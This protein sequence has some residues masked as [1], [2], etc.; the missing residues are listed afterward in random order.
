MM[1]FPADN[2]GKWDDGVVIDVLCDDGSL[3]IAKKVFC[4]ELVDKTNTLH[5]FI[6][7]PLANDLK[8]LVKPFNFQQSGISSVAVDGVHGQIA[9]HCTLHMSARVKGLQGLVDRRFVVELSVVK[10]WPE[11]SCQI[12]LG[13]RFREEQQ[14]T[15]SPIWYDTVVDYDLSNPPKSFIVCSND[16]VVNQGTVVAKSPVADAVVV[17]Q[18]TVVAKPP[19]AAAVVNSPPNSGAIVV[20]DNVAADTS[21]TVANLVGCVDGEETRLP[22]FSGEDFFMQFESLEQVWSKDKESLET[23]AQ[24]LRDL[25]ASCFRNDVSRKL[26]S[27]IL[28]AYSKFIELRKQDLE[29]DNSLLALIVVSTGD[30]WNVSPPQLTRWLNLATEFADVFRLKQV[31][32]SGYLVQPVSDSLKDGHVY[33]QFAPHRRYIRPDVGR[34]LTENMQSKVERGEWKVMDAKAYHTSQPFLVNDK[35]KPQGRIVFDYV[36]INQCVA[37]IDEGTMDIRSQLER[38]S[39]NA[40]HYDP[41][42]QR[43]ANTPVGFV[44][45]LVKAF[46]NVVYVDEQGIYAVLVN[47]LVYTPLRLPTGSRNAP[48]HLN[49]VLHEIFAGDVYV[50]FGHVADDFF[51]LNRNPDEAMDTLEAL[52]LRCREY[53]V[54][55]KLEGCQFL[56]RT[57]LAAGYEVS[58][59]SDNTIGWTKRPRS[60]T[61]LI[62]MSTPKTVRDVANVVYVCNY[63]GEHVFDFAGKVELLR[64]FVA[65]RAKPTDTKEAMARIKLQEGEWTEELSKVVDDLKK[66]AQ[67]QLSHSAPRPDHLF[68]IV[69]DA[70]KY[71]H[72]SILVQ[73]PKDQEHL[74]FED[75]KFTVIAT[76]SGRFNEHEVKRPIRDKELQAAMEGVVEFEKFYHGLMGPLY[77]FTDHKSLESLNAPETGSVA[78]VERHVR[79]IAKVLDCRPVIKHI[80][81]AKNILADMLSREENIEKVDL[82]QVTPRPLA[83]SA[84]NAMVTRATSGK[85]QVARHKAAPSPGLRPVDPALRE[86]LATT[87]EPERPRSDAEKKNG[88]WIFTDKESGRDV[89]C[90]PKQARELVMSSAHSHFLGHPGVKATAKYLSRYFWWP[91]MR[92]DVKEFVAKCVLCQLSSRDTTR[93]PLGRTYPGVRPWE[94]IMLDFT[95]MPLSEDG[96]GFA[97]IVLET[98]SLRLTVIPC[99]EETAMVAAQA[100]VDYGTRYV[101]PQII[102]SDKGKHF[103]AK[104]LKNLVDKLNCE[105]YFGIQNAPWTKGRVER[106]VR[107]FKEKMD[108]V[109]GQLRLPMSK[110]P[111]YVGIVEKAVNDTPSMRLGG[112]SANDILFWNQRRNDYAIDYNEG[113]NTFR[114]LP[115][116]GEVFEVLQEMRSEMDD[117]YKDLEKYRFSDSE[118][119][120]VPL[121]ANVQLPLVDGSYVLIAETPQ[122]KSIP[123]WTHVGQIE[124]SENDWV[125]V[126]RDVLKNTSKSY[127]VCM[128][129]PLNVSRLF[130]DMNDWE[131]IFQKALTVFDIEYIEKLKLDPKGNLECFVHWSDKRKNPSW[132]KAHTFVKELPDYFRT[133]LGTSVCSDSKVTQAL[134]NLL[135]KQAQDDDVDDVDA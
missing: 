34:K 46:D 27:D 47:G 121:R 32:N 69:A 82:E 66:A 91:N 127:H 55:L 60:M 97:L 130:T 2:V 100:I 13:H 57:I 56:R 4:G 58:V 74:D 89:I 9:G 128:L 118:G 30:F 106:A 10:G 73:F 75:K 125:Y 49:K 85:L 21:K 72:A 81:G 107:T 41:P 98:F 111:K 116:T 42:D 45:D 67:H 117:V 103:T 37:P 135:K 23:R 131:L 19:V 25:P 38:L 113:T 59:N 84:A 133:L 62:Q 54:G 63:F 123:V 3:P 24:V 83:L 93:P 28:D 115:L 102:W 68:A 119:G 53:N 43:K 12:S 33:P 79:W 16:M 61:S 95:Q 44:V 134:L 50:K 48:A 7:E 6:S 112:Y 90:V 26:H 64:K 29:V 71:T 110:W 11:G 86:L 122:N 1:V 52:F 40:G 78:T 109:L 31:A 36:D 129:K 20:V 104:L 51:G 92:G 105:Q 87:M 94:Q 124:K 65:A 126:V 99:R 18:G 80:P 22:N 17:N 76:H 120:R 96:Y 88:L 35:G 39:A 8:L 108:K 70:S 77:I 15:E 101:Y 132:N 114:E 5:G 14:A